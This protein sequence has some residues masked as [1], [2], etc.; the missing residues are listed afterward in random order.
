MF[1]NKD[2]KELY[3][4]LNTLAEATAGLG[5]RAENAIDGIIECIEKLNRFNANTKQRTLAIEKHL[6]IEFVEESTET[7]VKEAGYVS[8]KTEKQ[9]VQPK[10]VGNDVTPPT[11]TI[12]IPRKY[13][14]TIT[15]SHRKPH[16]HVTP[17]M[18]NEIRVLYSSGMPMKAIARRVGASVATVGRYYKPKQ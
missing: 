14:K 6:G 18:I 17:E 4:R 2:I 10:K 16:V 8:K 11:P 1:N 15:H 7:V 12:K 3:E 5:Q 9:P 13:I